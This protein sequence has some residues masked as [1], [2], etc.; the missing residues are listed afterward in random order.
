MHRVEDGQALRLSIELDVADEHVHVGGQ[1]DGLLDRPCRPDQAQVDRVIDG[2]C[3][4]GEDGRVVVDQTDTERVGRRGTGVIGWV[5]GGD[6]RP[7][8][9]LGVSLR[10]GG[11]REVTAST[12]GDIP[13]SPT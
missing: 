5:D 12:L 11:W 8:V 3:D 7:S 9:V 13:Q 4:R 10:P 6:G 1:G 2:G